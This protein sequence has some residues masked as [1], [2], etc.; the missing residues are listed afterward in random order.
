MKQILIFL[1]FL[2]G[3]YAANIYVNG[4]KVGS[5]DQ[6]ST[7]NGESKNEILKQE[8]KKQLCKKGYKQY[9]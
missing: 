9:C 1:V 5:S 3:L 8:G 6:N 7:Y 2:A 4:E